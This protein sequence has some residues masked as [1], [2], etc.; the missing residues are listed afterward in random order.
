[1]DGWETTFFSMWSTPTIS[2]NHLT[3][4]TRHRLFHG[5]APV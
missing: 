5:R 4:L 2:P 1:M 3:E